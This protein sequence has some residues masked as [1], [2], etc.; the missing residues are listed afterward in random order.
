M[1]VGFMCSTRLVRMLDEQP[2]D[3]CAELLP[4]ASVHDHPRSEQRATTCFSD[5]VV[6]KEKAY[7]VSGPDLRRGGA[8]GAGP[9]PPTNMGPPTKP[10]IFF[11][12]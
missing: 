2:T 10:F 3:R 6:R 7:V 5:V 8:R 4:V 9:R 1:R 12:S 11:H